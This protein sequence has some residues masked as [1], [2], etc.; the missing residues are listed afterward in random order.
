MLP[1][2]KL[3]YLQS[4]LKMLTDQLFCPL[5]ITLA[6]RFYN[7]LMLV[8]MTQRCFS[9]VMLQDPPVKEEIPIVIDQA[10]EPR[11]VG[12]LNEQ[13]MEGIIEFGSKL[14]GRIINLR[15]RSL[16]SL[17]QRVQF[18]GRDS[19]RGQVSGIALKALPK[20]VDLDEL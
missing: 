6:Q 1:E 10:D 11:A 20:P 18:T 17:A 16:T 19:L 5:T 9:I 13:A 15:K 7:L 14:E 4:T 3:S 8:M 12:C 2:R